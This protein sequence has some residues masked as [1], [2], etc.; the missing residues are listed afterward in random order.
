MNF[1]V[2]PRPPV[3]SVDS[4]RSVGN[5]RLRTTVTSHCT[6]FLNVNSPRRET[7]DKCEHLYSETTL[8]TVESNRPM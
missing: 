4:H 2:E 5:M 6:I 7:F 1:I 8:I 3:E